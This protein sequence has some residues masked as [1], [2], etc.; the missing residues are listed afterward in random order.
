MTNPTAMRERWGAKSIATKAGAG[1]SHVV[2]HIGS[3]EYPTARSGPAA[4]D[5]VPTNV[6]RRNFEVSKFTQPKW[7]TI[8]AAS[9]K[10]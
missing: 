6:N 1:A 5:S 8:Y 9:T 4:S 2:H 3:L 10:K 7:K